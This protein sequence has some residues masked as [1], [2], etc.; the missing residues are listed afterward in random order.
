MKKFLFVL[1]VLCSVQKYSQ[2]VGV[3][4]YYKPQMQSFNIV[5]IAGSFQNWSITDP[6]YIM[7]FDSTLNIYKKT[8]N[9][10]PGVYQ[11][12]FV[13]D[14]NW[15]TDPNNPVIVDPTYQNSQII[16]SDPMITYLMP[17]DTNTVT[18]TTLPHIRA[19]FAFN[20]VA[21]APLLTLKING[22]FITPLTAYYDSVRKI[23]DYPLS[24][25]NISLGLNTIIAGITVGQHFATKTTKIYIESDPKFDLLTENMI[26]KKPNI[27]VYGKILSTQI[28]S[29]VINVN[30]NNYT[31][32]PDSNNYFTYPVTLT[33][34]SNVVNVTVNSA[35]GSKSKSQVLVYLPDNQPVIQLSKSINNR[36]ISIMASAT[37]PAGLP[38]TYFWTQDPNNP[39]QVLLQNVTSPNIQIN[40]PAAK[41][42]YIFKVKV[43]DTKGKFNLAGYVVKAESDSIRVEGLSEHPDWVDKLVLY[44]I[45]TPTYGQTQT[46]L[47]GLLEKLDHLASLGV[48]AVWLTPVFDGNYNGYAVRNYYSINPLL[49]TEDDL[50]L[51]VQRA[52][53]KG[54]KILLDLVINHTWSAHPF[55]KNVAA[56]KALSPFANYY[57]WTGTPGISNYNYYYNWVDLPNLNV[58]NTELANYLYNLA[59]YWIREF[60][61]DGYRCDVAW[62]VEMRN[63][64]FWQ[65]MR[66]RLKNLKPEIFL[67]AESPANNIQNGTTLD[68]F[69]NK[70][71]AAYDW[72]LRGFGSGA[73]NYLLTGSS[74]TTLLTN[75]I[76]RSY[77]VNSFPLR[78]VE[79][80][81]HARATTEF[82]LKQSKLAHTVVFTLS[83]IPLIYG[84]GEVGELT[85]LNVINWSDPNNFLPYFK[86]LVEIRKR[87]IKNDGHVFVLNNTNAAMVESYITKSDSNTILTVA[88]FAN[89]PSALTVNFA[90]YISDTALYVYDLFKDTSLYVTS[91]QLNSLIFN[92]PGNEAR[93]YSLQKNNT[94]DIPGNENMVYSYKLEQNYPNPFNPSTIIS[95][96]IAKSGNVKLQ[97]YD[98]L[99]REIK[100]LINKEQN[101]GNY[102]ITWDGKDN[103]GYSLP[104]GIYLYSIISGD[105]ILTKKMV[106]IK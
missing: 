92:I 56:L 2:T 93:V 47:K 21:E 54:I 68:I 52:H 101:P 30:G 106:L 96:N 24:A 82:G 102:N 74:N 87:Y 32:M 43:T 11:Y 25:S 105:F 64:S 95:Y 75:V 46:G 9:L 100:T 16:V 28:N 15:F 55:F 10:A 17:I 71:D 38:L 98:I 97:V 27:I 42:E 65:E 72:D 18:P 86:K 88:N 36:T 13:V 80:H 50:R 73:F 63:P 23:L 81:D 37:S 5:R 3:T 91:S 69:N 66:R 14:G 45:Y 60:D 35:L 59:E 70:F 94:T 22:Q 99:G 90:N 20:P 83:G 79:N 29:V 104:S 8:V 77:P 1:L 34:D 49:G 89:N 53:Q 7:T 67:L 12:K 78:F 41:G 19:I 31:T 48:N 6:N 39:E 33:S 26:Y 103:F 62:G 61:I 84:G 4:F 57:L 76:N 44:E 51:I 40:I 85:Q 58:N